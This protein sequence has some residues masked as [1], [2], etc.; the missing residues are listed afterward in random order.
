MGPDG[1]AR[2]VIGAAA[3]RTSRARSVRPATATAAVRHTFTQLST[4][5]KLSMVTNPRSR[6]RST[7]TLRSRRVAFATRANARATPSR[8]ARN[9]RGHPT[10][11]H[12][13]QER[14]SATR[15]WHVWH[16]VHM[17]RQKKPV[18]CL[19]RQPSCH[20]SASRKRSRIGTVGR[21]HALTQAS[22]EKLEAAHVQQSTYRGFS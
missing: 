19:S 15:S 10:G 4:P 21:V 2:R 17:A 7:R 13:P 14:R 22:V 20:A 6:G 8:A 5:I 11:S 9:T 1:Q 12:E 18:I 16:A 3:N